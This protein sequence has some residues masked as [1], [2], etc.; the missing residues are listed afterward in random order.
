[1]NK[2]ELD[3]LYAEYQEGIVSWEDYS[4]AVKRSVENIDKHATGMHVQNEMQSTYI[5]D[6]IREER[7]K[8]AEQSVKNT[9]D[10]EVQSLRDAILEHIKRVDSIDG[11]ICT[12]CGKPISK[13]RLEAMPGTNICAKCLRPDMPEEDHD[14]ID[15]VLDNDNLSIEAKNI[16]LQKNAEAN[17][18][19]KELERKELEINN[20]INERLQSEQKKFYEERADLEYKRDLQAKA[21]KAK[22]QSEQS[23]KIKS[24]FIENRFMKIKNEEIF[25]YFNSSQYNERSP[26]LKGCVCIENKKYDISVWKNINKDN[27]PY[28]AGYL[29]INIMDQN[30]RIA[31]RQIAGKIGLKKRQGSLYGSVLIDETRYSIY[32]LQKRY[33]ENMDLHYWN[34]KIHNRYMPDE[35][36]PF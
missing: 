2:N 29:N 17:R 15:H 21:M 3:N 4:N 33:D 35:N 11:K 6:P 19:I 24:L 13:A 25:L 7:E 32:D 36:L 8:R 16:I 30:N 28:Y 1:M 12:K 22:I 31:Q 23:E 27:E 20:I 10:S 5:G 18:R 34:G 26:V 14:L 9:I